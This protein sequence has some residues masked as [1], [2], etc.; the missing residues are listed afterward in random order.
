MGGR[1]FLPKEG[2]AVAGGMVIRG[3]VLVTRGPVLSAGDRREN[4]GMGLGTITAASRRGD[5]RWAGHGS[6]PGAGAAA[7]V[8]VQ[9]CE[10][11][12]SVSSKADVTANGR[13]GLGSGH[14]E[15]LGLVSPDATSGRKTCNSWLSTNTWACIMRDNVRNTYSVIPYRPCDQRTGCGGEADKRDQRDGGSGLESHGVC[16]Y[17]R[18]MRRAELQGAEEK[19]KWRVSLERFLPRDVCMG[20][21][22]IFSFASLLGIRRRSRFLVRVIGLGSSGFWNRHAGPTESGLRA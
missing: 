15:I 16:V 10:E 18:R 13:C 20:S 1:V 9:P 7:G 12:K 4:V 3:V 19:L 14:R 11:M 17:V 22:V 2:P 8:K 6:L 21:S 5:A